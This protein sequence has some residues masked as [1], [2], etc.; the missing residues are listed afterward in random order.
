MA[1][2]A[3]LVSCEMQRNLSAA[4][5]AASDLV[6]QMRISVFPGAVSVEA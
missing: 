5:H 1:K 4:E 2:S 6:K 3:G